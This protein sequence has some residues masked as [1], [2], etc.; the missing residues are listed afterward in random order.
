MDE[1]TYKAI[2]LI[3]SPYREIKGMPIQARGAQG[4]KGTIILDPAYA[5]GLM[6]VGKPT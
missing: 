3:H 5:G 1:I 4:V 6:G 2:G